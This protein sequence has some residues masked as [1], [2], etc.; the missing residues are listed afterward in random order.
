MAYATI[1]DLERRWRPL[2][3]DESDKAQALL[4]DAAYMLDATL[5]AA[6]IQDVEDGALV[7]VSCNM[8]KRVMLPA[9]SGMYGVSQGTVSADIYSQ[10]M[11]FANPSGDM[12]ITAIERRML[13]ITGGY[14]GSIPAK[15]GGCV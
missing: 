8:V 3:A 14:I 13:G 2:T 6:G 9:E 4:D 5:S 12:Y 11:T 10:S 1:D 15:V 7:A